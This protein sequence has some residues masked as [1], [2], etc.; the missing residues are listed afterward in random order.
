MLI[1]LSD[2]GW[3]QW[4]GLW[5]QRPESVAI[6]AAGR[7]ISRINDPS[8][9]GKPAIPREHVWTGPA[10]DKNGEYTIGRNK[11]Y[12]FSKEEAELLIKEISTPTGSK[13]VGPAV[14]PFT[15]LC[16]AY[17][18]DDLKARGNVLDY[19]G[20]PGGKVCVAEVS[21]RSARNGATTYQVLFVK[22]GTD[23]WKISNVRPAKTPGDF[24]GFWPKLEPWKP[25][26]KGSDETT[27][28]HVGNDLRGEIPADF[29]GTWAAR[30]P[31]P[32][33][34]VID[35]TSITWERGS[36][37]RLVVPTGKYRIQDRGY[38]IAFQVEEVAFVDLEARKV[39]THWIDVELSLEG[40]KLKVFFPPTQTREATT[41]PLVVT[42][43]AR[44][45][46]YERQ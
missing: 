12:G 41:S 17:F 2:L 31:V 7:V 10:M 16:R 4:Q 30:E 8:R 44:S 18:G 19:P 43:P 45:Y 27:K 46:V 20:G 5:A 1:E 37:K 22:P 40:K 23:D 9:S 29:V 11:F 25:E 28:P 33:K 21:L 6:K 14:D 34:F 15:A 32:G 42:S 24:R 26:T 39:Q 35:N 36:A 13:G 3:K 38:K